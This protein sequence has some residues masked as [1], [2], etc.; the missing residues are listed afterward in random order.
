MPICQSIGQLKMHTIT[1][2]VLGRGGIYI[3]IREGTAWVSKRRKEGGREMHSSLN[4]QR[5]DLLQ[6][7]GETK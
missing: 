1:S 6:T 7:M 4:T 2:T 5:A 3:C